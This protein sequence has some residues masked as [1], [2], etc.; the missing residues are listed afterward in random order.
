MA[1][2]PTS[3]ASWLQASLERL[4]NHAAP[5]PFHPLRRY[6]RH[7]KAI[8]KRLGAAGRGGAYGTCANKFIALLGPHPARAREDPGGTG[9]TIIVESTDDGGIAVVGKRDRVALE[10]EAYGA[11]TDKFIALLRPHPA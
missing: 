1:P 10:R 6:S 9:D 8:Q 5:T 7:Q 11:S 3:F 2:V 4:N